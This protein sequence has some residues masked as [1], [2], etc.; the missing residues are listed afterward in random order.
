MEDQTVK[1]EC[2]IWDC[3]YNLWRQTNESNCNLKRIKLGARPIGD[4][5]TAVEGFCLNMEDLR[6]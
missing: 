3:K 6:E 4:G 1:V 5:N 2:M